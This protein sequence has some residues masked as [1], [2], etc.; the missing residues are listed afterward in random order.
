MKKILYV[1]L[2]FVILIGMV[3][4]ITG[5]T[6]KNEN[7]AV[8]INDGLSES[9]IKE[10]EEKLKSLD[11]VNSI[12]YTTKAEVYE[13]VK[14]KLGQDVLEIPGYTKEYHPFPT[15]FT[16][17]VKKRKNN[18]KIIEEIEMIDGVKMVKKE[19]TVNDLLNAEKNYIESKK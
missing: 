4:L 11:G 6:E 16:L 19:P 8:Y 14:E 15:Y 10:I 5:C 1:T 12:Q 2:I 18:D 7:I 3:L 13:E 9:K 17:E